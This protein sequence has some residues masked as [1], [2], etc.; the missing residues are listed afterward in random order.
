MYLGRRLVISHNMRLLFAL[1]P[2]LS[3]AFVSCVEE[4]VLDLGEDSDVQL[5]VLSNFSQDGQVKVVVTHTRSVQVSPDDPFSFVANAEVLLLSD[6]DSL[7]QQLEFVPSEG[8]IV[9]HYTSADFSPIPGTK[10]TVRVSAPGFEEV[11]EACGIIPEPVRITG[12]EFQNTYNNA[13]PTR[14][15]IDFEISVSFKDPA[16]VE[17]FYHLTFFQELMPKDGAEK[18]KM[19][20][21]QVRGLADNLPMIPYASRQGALIQDRFFDGD[22]VTYRFSGNFSFDGSKYMP[23]QFISELR[24][25]SEAYYDYHVSLSR[26]INTEDG[27]LSPG[28]DLDGNTR[29]GFGVF[30]GYSQNSSGSAIFQ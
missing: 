8:D 13:I 30:A 1:L 23:G 14:T 17:N 20:P 24:T 25:V 16:E 18:P 7:L 10:Y 2:I 29:G 19:I 22:E 27:D 11:V 15:M 5:I 26:Q 12:T 21:M 6:N 28:F 4:I 3:L 9:A